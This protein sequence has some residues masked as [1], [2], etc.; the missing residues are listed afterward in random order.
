[1]DK[2]EVNM[3]SVTK[4]AGSETL[5]NDKT[6]NALDE[7]TF[8]SVVSIEGIESED[9]AAS[10]EE[11]E[12]YGRSVRWPAK[13]LEGEADGTWVGISSPFLLAEHPT[14]P[15]VQINPRIL[16]ST[17]G[18][19]APPS[20]HLPQS[21]MISTESERS[22]SAAVSDL[23][24]LTAFKTPPF[25]LPAFP[26]RLPLSAPNQVTSLFSFSL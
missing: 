8:S 6:G 17:S 18:S 5:E 23:Q 13:L 24:S 25:P 19:G 4:E 3:T 11:G 15:F 7:T 2:D 10:S 12:Q 26:S 16:S 1:M 22:T 21:D 20:H 14:D 9:S